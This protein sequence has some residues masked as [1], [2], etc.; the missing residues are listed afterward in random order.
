MDIQSIITIVAIAIPTV[1]NVVTTIASLV[2]IFNNFDSLKKEVKDRTDLS[3]FRTQMA[4]ILEENIRL[5]EEMSKLIEYSD[6]LKSIT[7][8]RG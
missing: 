8:K 6:V 1:S 4:R 5:K 3:E 7:N 2:K